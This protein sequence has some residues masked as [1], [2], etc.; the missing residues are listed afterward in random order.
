MHSTLVS[1]TEQ[2]VLLKLLTEVAC[3]EEGFCSWSPFFKI[4]AVVRPSLNTE[5]IVTA[6][7]LVK[8]SLSLFQQEKLLL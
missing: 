4:Q 5:G 8:A 3:K 2:T 1:Q 6:C 7:E